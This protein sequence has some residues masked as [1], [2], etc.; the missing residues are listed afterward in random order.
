[1]TKQEIKKVLEKVAVEFH[2]DNF[3]D[4]NRPVT[5][6]RQVE[7][8]DIF[9]CI[10]GYAVDGHDYASTAMEKGAALLITEKKLPLD[11]PQIVVTNS[12]VATAILCKKYYHDPTGKLKLIGVTGTNGKTTVTYLFHQILRSMGK[13]VGLIG[14]LGYKINDTEYNTERTTPDIID[15]NKIFIQMLNAGIEYVVMEVSSHAI[16]LNRTDHLNFCAG[17]FTNLTQ[18]HLDFHETMEN[19]AET[20]FKFFQ[21]VAD[22]DG[23]AIINID[24]KY[25][26]ELYKREHHSKISVSFDEADIKIT[27]VH[28]SLFETKFSLARDDNY[29]HFHTKLI[30]EYNIYNLSQSLALVQELF[31]ALPAEELHN[32]VTELNSVPGRLQKANSKPEVG[33][34]IDYAHSPDA[35]ENVIKTLR[36]TCKSRII[37]VFGAGGERD[38]GKRPLMFAAA[39]LAD[40]TIITNDNPR[41]EDPGDIIR[42]ITAEAEN[43]ENFWIIRDR[44]Q[45]IISAIDLAHPGDVVIIAG[46]GHEKYQEIKGEKIGFDDL[47]IAENY[48]LLENDQLAVPI[49]SLMLEKIF[50]CRM[51]TTSGLIKH[52]S[53]DSRKILPDSLFFALVGDKYDGH[54][55]IKSALTNPSCIAVVDTKHQINSDRIIQVEDTTIAY[56]RLASIYKKLFSIKS[57]AITGSYGKTTTKEY[58]YNILNQ[59]HPTLKTYSNENNL[60]GLPKT[61]FKLSSIDHF[62]IFELGSN[63]FGEI[64]ALSDI[65][66]ADINLITSIGPAHL[67]FFKDEMGVFQEKT[68]IFRG[69]NEIRLYPGDDM[70]FRNYSGITF[71]E[72]SNCDYRIT[73]I[74]SDAESTSFDLKNNHYKILSPF[75]DNAKNA[76]V[77]AVVATELKFSPEE[78]S[79]GLA[80]PLEISNRMQFYKFNEMLV[81]SDCYNANPS[82]MR[83]AIKFWQRYLPNR[84]HIAILGDMLE[85]GDLAE[86]HHREISKILKNI[87]NIN[88][89]S[90]GSLSNHFEVKDHFSTIDD[91]IK[92]NIYENFPKDAVVLLKASRSIKLEKLI[93]IL[94]KR[95]I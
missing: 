4:A 70:R 92:S 24:N 59:K 74:F 49:D 79:S 45:A 13:Q 77:A 71:G 9:I 93:K 94:T 12:R 6:S 62:A 1:M 5:D 75:S 50:E 57:I 30:G 67:E 87:E 72:N 68:S 37:C 21:Q 52:I 26:K 88:T 28:P 54:D 80:L 55:F 23:L 15:L 56:G 61:I 58:L 33:V 40:L 32:I 19:Y 20:K 35:L 76:S 89:I 29:Q 22:N 60:V 53:T 39:S 17:I 27:N 47:E 65:C 11:F 46:K 44:K 41:A 16:A 43:L 42:D 36:K 83:A 34:Y 66:Q 18:D 51:K 84:P 48:Q 95:G 31:P 38:K 82:S 81:I 91:L 25:G 3:S 2:L 73:H 63:H 78:I 69:K 8:D 10:P 86:K 14:T 90:V 64:K 85:L 7:T